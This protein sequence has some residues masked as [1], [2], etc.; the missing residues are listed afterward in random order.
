MGSCSHASQVEATARV[1]PAAAAVLGW[2]PGHPTL[3]WC[4]G[5][6]PQGHFSAHHCVPALALLS[7]PSPGS[8]PG[9]TSST[10]EPCTL[11]GTPA[12]LPCAC[13][14]IVECPGGGGK[15]SMAV[16]FWIQSWGM[17]CPSGVVAAA[18]TLPCC[19]LTCKPPN[20]FRGTL[21][22]QKWDAADLLSPCFQ[23]GI[24][25]ISC[26]H[27]QLDLGLPWAMSPLPLALCGRL[28]FFHDL[29]AC[30]GD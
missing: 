6:P 18:G 19:R 29:V 5:P 22:L 2:V 27:Q 15:S 21:P 30:L 8:R 14:P 17:L 16:Q 20:A 9:P 23:N 25:Q 1:T 24:I 3:A 12:R 28:S 13:C 10:D 26:S 11:A 7:C 4:L